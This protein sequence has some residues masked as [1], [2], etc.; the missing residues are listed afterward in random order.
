MIRAEAAHNVPGRETTSPRT[1]VPPHATL[2]EHHARYLEDRGVDHRRALQEFWTARKPSEMPEP[3]SSYQRRKTPALIAE[4]HSPDLETVAFQMY[5]DYPGKDSKG[6]KLKWVSP[7]GERARMVLGANPGLVEEVRTG[8]GPLWAVEGITRV[9]AVA[10]FG[11]PAVG[12]AG[13]FGWRRKGG[14]PLECWQHVNLRGR[15]VLVA[16]D[17][18]YRTNENVQKALAGLVAFLEAQGARVL[19]VDVPEINGDP[20]TGLDDWIAANGH[21][22]PLERSAQPFK[23]VDVARERLSK[24]EKLAATVEDLW[25]QQDA[26]PMVKRGECT[27]RSTACELIKDAERRGKPCA[28]GVKVSPSLRT[29]A[30]AVRVSLQGQANSLKR[31]EESGFLRPVEEPRKRGESQAY[32]LLSNAPEK[33][34]L[35]RQVGERGGLKEG[36][37]TEQGKVSPLS[38]AES[39]LRVNLTR[40]FRDEVPELRWPT[41]LRRQERDERGHLVEVYEYLA[42]LGKK[43][44]EI[45]RFLLESG[46][47]TTIPELMERFASSRARPRDF[48]RRNLDMLTERPAIVLVEGDVVSL[49]PSWRE[50]LENARELAGEQEAARLQAEKIA[51]QREAFR[52]REEHQPDPE[53]EMPQVDDMRDP[54]SVHPGGC[55]CR[56][57]EERF[58]RAVGEHV[59][60]CRCAACFKEF[61]RAAREKSGGRLVPLQSR[62][63]P[64]RG[65][66]PERENLTKPDLAAV[67]PIRPEPSVEPS[68]RRE[69]S[70]PDRGLPKQANGVFAHGPECLCDWCDD[71]PEPSYARPVGGG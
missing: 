47:V 64:E 70:T 32:I 29:L 1:G 13:C 9:A 34:A 24:N 31:L 19:V 63:R 62:K 50:A 39:S 16:P 40:T 58:G 10:S 46:G 5:S 11:I 68:R 55:A 43:R 59:E 2:A 69:E 27:D 56:A 22:A 33:C 51:R 49:A 17:A 12:Y 67:V 41:I 3:F 21:P 38:Q 36:E 57:C 65:A 35:G 25:A 30:P 53:P 14:E 61:K 52:R 71:A 15:L 6:K 60:G 8:A 23:P 42:R 66:A 44:G 20:N 4:F 7:P 26:M 18:D 54:W 48:R 37:G 28:G 45:L